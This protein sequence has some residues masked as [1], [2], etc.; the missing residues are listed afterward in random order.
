MNKYKISVIIPV[1]N[2]EN[3]IN[4]TLKSI[5][6]QTIGIENIQVILVND[7]SKD[8]SGK[9]CEE[10]KE[11]YPDNVTYIDKENG[12]VSSARNE[13]IK[14]IEG[15]YTHFLDS[16]DY[17][18]EGA[19]QKAYDILEENEDVSL[20]A[21]RLKFFEKTKTYHYMD[22]RF[23]K[24]DRIV[25]LS[26][27]PNNPIVHNPTTIVRSEF[28]KDH[29][30][31]EKVK[32]SEDFKFLAEIVC[33]HPKV[34][35]IASELYYYRRR[36]DESSAIQ[37]SLLNKS[38][39]EVT[40]KEVYEYILKLGKKYKKSD[41]WA[42]Y[43]VVNDVSFR[44]FGTNLSVLNDKEKK[45]YI[46]EIRKI[47]NMCDDEII[48]SQINPSK[49]KVLRALEFKYKKPIYTDLVVKD[50]S[51]TLYGKKILDLNELELKIDVLEVRNNKLNI[52]GSFDMFLNNNFNVYIKINDEYH[53]SKIVKFKDN[54]N[55][56]YSHDNN[57]YITYFNEYIDFNEGKIE[58]YIKIK[59]EY[60]KLKLIYQNHSKLN[61]LPHSYYKKNGLTMTHK[62]NTLIISK[63]SHF[64]LIKY[65]KD[66]LLIKKDILVFGFIVLYKLTYPFV[67]HDNYILSDRYD[68]AGDNGEWMFNYL[69]NN[70]KKKNV[71]FALKKK[72]KD[73]DMMKKIGKVIHFNTFNYYLKYM[74]SEV[75]LSSHVDDYIRKPF[76]KRQLYLSSYLKYKFVFLQH[77]VTKNDMSNWLYKSNKNIDILVCSANMEY[78]EFLN[79]RYMYDKDVVKLTGMPRYDNLFNSKDKTENLIAFMPTWRNTLC[80]PVIPRTQ[81]RRYNDKF[82]ES[83]Y[84]KFYNGLVTDKRLINALK[85]SKCK[86]LFCLHPS[87]TSQLK[88]FKN[89]EYVTFKT[90]VYYPEVFK[91]AKLLLTDYSSVAFDFG[92]TKKPIIYSHFDEDH[93]YQ[94]HTVLTDDGEFSYEKDGFGVVTYDYESTLNE[95]IRI[96]NNNF[97]NEKKYIDRVNKFFKYQDNNNSKRVY[98]EVVKML[99]KN[100]L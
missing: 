65:L 38:Y 30:F 80:G 85:K 47:Y 70:I 60:H 14:H 89:N 98:E 66:V 6:N 9:I 100:K 5:E 52:T 21:L 51:I 33:K 62:N 50:D 58:F 29:K 41:K 8:N 67:R 90:E 93:L 55:H 17:I 34:A 71:Y 64:N 35:F 84:Y 26:I 32:I 20:C 86:I 78:N 39:Y 73:N 7:G 24:G 44:L 91:K 1:Y 92:Y 59:N 53:K 77:G 27:E 31:D 13:G 43:C 16:D 18:T 69:C 46:E 25:D 88:D 63:K 40:P 3:Y 94:I 81:N 23:K 72:S 97:K 95:I 75:V 83:E 42:Q 28:V 56:L 12:G 10:F 37:N 15:K 45:D 57:Y 11:K 87:F 68:V 22:Y 76:G 61:E 36:L 79:E 54:S 19:Y 74:N 96:I 2:V 4:E 99:D 48:S 49:N 82:K